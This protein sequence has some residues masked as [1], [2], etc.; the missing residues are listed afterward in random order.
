MGERK[1]IGGVEMMNIY[2][3]G[4]LLVNSSPGEIYDEQPN[5]TSQYLSPINFHNAA[6]RA[7]HGIYALPGGCAKGS[8]IPCPSSPGLNIQSSKV[9]ALISSKSN[10]A[11]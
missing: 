1:Q 2:I 6:H 3:G 10:V 4:T 5:S 9:H 8:G 7:S 11:V